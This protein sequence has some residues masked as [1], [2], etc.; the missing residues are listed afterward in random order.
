MKHGVKHKVYQVQRKQICSHKVC[1]DVR[2]WL[3]HKFASVFAIGQLHHQSA[4][5]PG[6][7]RLHN[8]RG[9]PLPTRRSAALKFC[10]R[11]ASRWN[12]WMMMMVMKRTR[13]PIF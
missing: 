11:L 5:A 8:V 9:L 12:S 1:S 10:S 6:T 13:G 7:T 4:T 2:L 3:I